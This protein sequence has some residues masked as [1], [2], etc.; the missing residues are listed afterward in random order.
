MYEMLFKTKIRR[1]GTSF[2][3]LIPRKIIERNKIKKGEEIEIAL[4]KKRKLKLIEKAF[5][6]AKGAGGFNRQEPDRTW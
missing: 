4:L 1:I 5:G 6:I 3:V 2:G